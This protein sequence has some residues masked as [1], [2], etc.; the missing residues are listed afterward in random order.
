MPACPQPT[1]SS[2]VSQRTFPRIGGVTTVEDVSAADDPAAATESTSLPWIL[3][4]PL[5]RS[6]FPQLTGDRRP[7]SNVLCVGWQ[8]HTAFSIVRMMIVATTL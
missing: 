3:R 2:L 4:A 6:G 1:G 8:L 7:P 5:C